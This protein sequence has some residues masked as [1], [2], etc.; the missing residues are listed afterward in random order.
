VISE[1]AV[2]P[3]FG[4]LWGKKWP[5]GDDADDI[6]AAADLPVQ[7]FLVGLLDQ[8][9]RRF[10]ERGEQ[11]VRPGLVEMVGATMAWPEICVS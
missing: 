3:R 8:I 4:L 6:S 9:C 7:P 5:N 1:A 2:A 11:N 10:R